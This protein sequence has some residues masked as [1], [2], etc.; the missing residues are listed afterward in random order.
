MYGLNSTKQIILFKIAHLEL[1]IDVY[2]RLMV[3]KYS[4]NNCYHILRVNRRSFTPVLVFGFGGRVLNVCQLFSKKNLSATIY[5]RPLLRLKNKRSTWMTREKRAFWFLRS[6]ISLSL[7]SSRFEK[8]R[9]HS[10]VWNDDLY[11]TR[12]DLTETKVPLYLNPS[13]TI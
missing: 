12:P 7:I 10:V 5:M 9:Y 8:F 4:K 3:V 6:V 1:A 13:Q 2:S 11:D